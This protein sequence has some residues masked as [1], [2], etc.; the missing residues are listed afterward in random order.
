VNK[1]NRLISARK[2]KGFT[3]EQLAEMLEFQKSTVS[4]WENGHS[5]PRLPDAFRVA[6]LLGKDVNYLF[7]SKKVQ[8]SHT[9]ENSISNS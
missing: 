6:K 5:T 1:N 3:Q 8:E 9:T 2:E 7:F 4:N